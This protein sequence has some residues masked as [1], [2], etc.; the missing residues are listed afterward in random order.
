MI[1]EWLQRISEIFPDKQMSFRARK[2][3]VA[4]LSS[5]VFCSAHPQRWR[6]VLSSE[7]RR[8]KVPRI[9]RLKSSRSWPP[10]M[11]RRLQRAQTPM[12][13]NIYLP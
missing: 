11:A 5:D 9:F 7:E 6:Q 1:I 4:L 3:R 2:R 8:R 10:A 13:K 12:K